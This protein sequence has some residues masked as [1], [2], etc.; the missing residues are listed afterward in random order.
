MIQIRHSIFETNSSTTHSL[1]I[2][3]GKVDNKVIKDFKKKYGNYII[4]GLNDYDTI[5]DIMHKDPV[6]D[7]TTPFQVKADILYF[8]MYVWTECGNI[9]EFI[10]NKNLLTKRLIE[11]GFKV[12][13]REDPKVIEE[14]DWHKYDVS[15]NMFENLWGDTDIEEVISFLFDDHVLYYTWCDEC[16]K[17]CPQAIV[18][19]EERFLKYK[20]T[21]TQKN[22]IY[23]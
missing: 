7:E 4:F 12:E 10:H 3:I 19:A 16:M 17:E 13:F 14:Y 1:T 15:E 21:E 22:Y 8:S 6:I 2:T 11:M 18:E 9:A 20:E 5:Y 23:R